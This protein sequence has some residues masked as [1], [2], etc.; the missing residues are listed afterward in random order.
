MVIMLKSYEQN[1]LNIQHQSAEP[2]WLLQCKFGTHT[3]TLKRVSTKND[4]P[5]IGQ[6]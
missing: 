2:A 5:L 4:S 3:V 6:S 1:I